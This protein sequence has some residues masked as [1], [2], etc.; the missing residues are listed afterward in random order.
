MQNETQNQDTDT[1]VTQEEES[2]AQN[3][4][5][6]NRDIDPAATMSSEDLVDSDPNVTMHPEDL[7]DPETAQEPDPNVTM[8]PEDLLDPETAQEPIIT[9]W[10]LGRP[11]EGD[12]QYVINPDG[13]VTQVIEADP[14]DPVITDWGLGRPSEGDQQYVINPDGTLDPIITDWGL[15]R[16]SEGAYDH[17]NNPGVI[18]EPVITDWGLGRPSGPETI[19]LAAPSAEET[20]RID[21]SDPDIQGGCGFGLEYDED[22]DVCLPSPDQFDFIPVLVGDKPLPDTAGGYLAL[23]GEAAGD[24]VLGLGTSITAGGAYIEKALDW[25]GEDGGPIGLGFQGLGSTIGFATE[26]TG[27]I[28]SGVGELVGGASDAV[29]DAVDAVGDAAGAVGDAAED[30]WDTVSGWF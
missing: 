23:P 1:Q 16:P 8:H 3:E 10:G 5:P 28:V 2:P 6:Q 18:V 22:L 29:G 17:D 13:S 12:Q 27:T 7:L 4:T 25:Y 15:G 19:D 11:S 14:S 21:D 30:A 24:V 9:D 26:A 20:G